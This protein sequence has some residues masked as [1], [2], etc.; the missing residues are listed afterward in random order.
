MGYRDAKITQDSIWR[1]AEGDWNIHF[2][3]KEGQQYFFGDIKWKGNSN[4]SI[5]ELSKVLG[6]KK[7]EVYN[8]EL[9]D[10]RLSFSPDG[11]DISTLYMDNGYLFFR[12]EPHRNRY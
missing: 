2:T 6:I 7:G 3:L 10:M 12:A 1:G 9:L 8:K 11:R 4:Y 5:E